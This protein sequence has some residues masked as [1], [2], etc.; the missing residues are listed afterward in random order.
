ML[1]NEIKETNE[2][3]GIEFFALWFSISLGIAIFLFPN[4]IIFKSIIWT[5]C[6]IVCSLYSFI[7]LVKWLNYK[8]I[9]YSLVAM[10]LWT[11]NL[12]LQS[13]SLFFFSPF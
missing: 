12:V 5:G 3:A 1:N 13:L 7:S 2:I 4:T 6:I 10:L 8:K 9:D 11:L